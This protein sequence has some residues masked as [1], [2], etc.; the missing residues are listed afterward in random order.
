MSGLCCRYVGAHRQRRTSSRDF[1]CSRSWSPRESPERP[2]PPPSPDRARTPVMGLLPHSC[3]PWTTGSQTHRLTAERGSS[4]ATFV[5][6]A[7]RHLVFPQ[8]SGDWRS[9]CESRCRLPGSW[10]IFWCWKR[11]P[12]V[13]SLQRAASHLLLSR[14]NRRDSC[15][16]VATRR[17]DLVNLA[18]YVPGAGSFAVARPRVA[19]SAH[20]DVVPWQPS[21][22]AAAGRKDAS[23]V[24]NERRRPRSVPSGRPAVRRGEHVRVLMGIN[25]RP[26]CQS[27]F[28]PS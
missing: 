24:P 1:F 14:A 3:L 16:A 19:T 17:A 13:N 27:Q 12:L 28:P 9:L 25:S 26:T 8:W 15:Y 7:P 22:T 6:R 2:F 21:G 23:W 20:P 18:D 5:R 4:L 11:S 10:C